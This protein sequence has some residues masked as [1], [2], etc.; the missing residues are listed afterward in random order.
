[1]FTYRSGKRKGPE[2]ERHEREG[3]VLTVERICESPSTAASPKSSVPDTS[4]ASDASDLLKPSFGSSPCSV[5]M[6]FCSLLPSVIMHRMSQ[7]KALELTSSSPF[8]LQRKRLKTQKMEVAYSRFT[9]NCSFLV[10]FF[11]HF[12]T[13][14]S[15]LLFALL[16]FL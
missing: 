3:E 1:M 11:P 15:S 2:I 10:W 12:L 6:A 14:H 4:A 7:L 8:I 16:Y 9:L 13:S 5:F